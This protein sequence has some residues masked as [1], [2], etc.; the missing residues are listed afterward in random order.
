MKNT[1]LA[2]RIAREA[3]I[4]QAAAADQLDEVITSILKTLKRGRSAH[5]PG[6]GRL[7]RDTTGGVRFTRNPPRS[8][9]GPR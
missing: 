5:L 6:L 8:S 1:D 4:S 3:G 7:R 9:S 2:G